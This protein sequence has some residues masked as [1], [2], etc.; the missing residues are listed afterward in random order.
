MAIQNMR[1]GVPV[2]G[3]LKIGATTT[4]APTHPYKFDH[5][6]ITGKDRDKDGNLIPDIGLLNQLVDG[7]H[8]KLCGGCKRSNEL[9]FPKGL[10]RQ[11]PIMIPYNDIEL[12]FPNR[13][14]YY[15]GRTAYC[16][17][18]GIEAQRLTVTGTRKGKGKGGKEFPVYGPPAP[19]EPCGSACPDFERRRCKPNGKL[20]LVLGIHDTVGTVM[21]FKTTSWAS[22]PNI[23]NGLEEISRATGGILSGIPLMFEITEEA[24]SPKDGSAAGNAWI[25]RVV[26]V[27]GRQ[28]LLEQ[29]SEMLRLRAPLIQEVRRL[30]SSIDRGEIWE[31]TPEEIA[32][33]TREFY[34]N[35]EEPA[36]PESTPQQES[37]EQNP[38]K[39]A[40]RA[41]PVGV[42]KFLEG[43]KGGHS[44]ETYIP[45]AGLCN[46]ST[47]N[48]SCDPPAFGRAGEHCRFVEG[49]KGQ[50][51]FEIK[52]EPFDDRASES[53]SGPPLELNGGTAPDAAPAQSGG[54][55][56]T[57][58]DPRITDV[59]KGILIAKAENRAGAC[60]LAADDGLIILSDVLN[61]LG[62]T[63]PDPAAPVGADLSDVRVGE[64]NAFM[65]A[66]AA[67]GDGDGAA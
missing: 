33:H 48:R 51:S 7:G 10:P 47:F 45:A 15:R 26:P 40:T 43:H 55:N 17:G 19:H 62:V 61:G 52:T 28:Q 53:P 44:F 64:M 16:T 11:I 67:W 66:I 20:R 8:V 38:P 5:I 46:A 25:A 56:V 24:V 34:Q 21:E 27:V 6:E 13:M 4:T 31:E 63:E 35:G 23:Q 42:C 2:I 22:I 39:P 58:A 36:E 29:A 12:A 59:Q 18:D 41:C 54:R 50:H 37:Q 65:A 30:E 9:G 14:A 60:G 57:E 49:H 1:S 3:Y 32:A